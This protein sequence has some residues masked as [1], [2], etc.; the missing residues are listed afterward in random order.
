MLSDPAQAPAAQAVRVVMTDQDSI[1]NHVN[2]SGV[3]MTR[4]AKN[5]DAARALMEYMVSPDAQAWYA[6]NNYEY[7]VVEG[8]EVSDL[9][10]SW[11]P[12]GTRFDIDAVSLLGQYNSEAVKLFDQVGWP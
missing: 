1:G 10:K 9:V 12:E 5:T 8:V 2:V 4:Y 3:A 7:P 11:T 6:S